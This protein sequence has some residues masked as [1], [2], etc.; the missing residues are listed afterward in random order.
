MLAADAAVDHLDDPDYEDEG[1]VARDSLV[2][3]EVQVII[4]ELGWPIA[5]RGQAAPRVE[6]E[7]GDRDDAGDVEAAAAASEHAS[8]ETSRHDPSADK[9]HER[10]KGREHHDSAS[11]RVDRAEAIAFLPAW[12]IHIVCLAAISSDI[13]DVLASFF[14]IV[15]VV[16]SPH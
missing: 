4:L 10:V 5:E 13:N 1:C 7:H 12:I 3:A 16:L 9:H 6:A 8:P 11:E 2:I 15:A 14:S